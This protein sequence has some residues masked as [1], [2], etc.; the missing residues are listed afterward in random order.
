MSDRPAFA[1]ISEVVLR[2]A[3]L[4]GMLGFY[5][6]IV[7]LQSWKSSPGFELLKVADVDSP[8]GRGGHPQLLALVDRTEH[9][10]GWR[11][12]DYGDIDPRASSLDHL[13]LEISGDAFEAERLR[14]EE[15]CE[16][17]VQMAAFPEL[18]ARGL[19]FPDPEGNVVEFACHTSGHRE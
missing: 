19:F 18:N 4:P 14:L 17:D 2:V 1:G 6:E 13:A 10:W 9:P 12:L 3:D 8:L 15:T 7:G 11:G 16:L 5:T